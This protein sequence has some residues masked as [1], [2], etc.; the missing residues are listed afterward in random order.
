MIAGI[1]IDLPAVTFGKRYSVEMVTN[2]IC[3]GTASKQ[4]AF[5]SKIVPKTCAYTQCQEQALKRC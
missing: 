2:D 1:I 3:L 5:F 4:N